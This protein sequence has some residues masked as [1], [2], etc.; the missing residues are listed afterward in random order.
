MTSLAAAALRRSEKKNG[1]DLKIILCL[2]AFR[3]ARLPAR[4]A[5]NGAA[6]KYGVTKP[7]I[8]SHNAKQ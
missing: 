4:M 8:V 6:L 2:P 5:G 1:A 7:L 3:A